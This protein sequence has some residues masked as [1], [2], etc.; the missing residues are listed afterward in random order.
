MKFTSF[1]IGLGTGAAVAMLFAPQSGKRTREILSEK[2][3]DG[4]R[5]AKQRAQELRDGANDVVDRAAKK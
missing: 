5:Y 2:A 1:V 3:N 4:R